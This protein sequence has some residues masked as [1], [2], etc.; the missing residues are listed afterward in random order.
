VIDIPTLYTVAYEELLRL[1]NR[2]RRR[3]KASPTVNTTALV[4]EAWFKLR[5][6]PQY[7]NLEREAFLRIAARAMR[8]VL[9]D[10]ARIAHA[11]KRQRIAITLSGMTDDP[12]DPSTPLDVIEF[13]NAMSALEKVDPRLAR[14]V[15]LHVFSG[16]AFDEI[17]RCEDVSERT[18]FRA[19]RSARVFLLDYMKTA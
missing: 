9:I 8:Q 12:S 18:I 3:L 16:L 1:A 7:A 2:E 10:Y 11:H 19:W 5:A 14:I 15:D 6:L 17:A 13:D 4:H